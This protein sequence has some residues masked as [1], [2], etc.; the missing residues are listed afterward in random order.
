MLVIF[1]Q[2][3]VYH[4]RIKGLAM[5]PILYLLWQLIDRL[6]LGALDTTIDPQYNRCHHEP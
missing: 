5:E 6:I 4:S 3:G 2:G 1:S